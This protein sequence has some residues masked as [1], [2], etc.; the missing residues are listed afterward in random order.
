M[1]LACGKKGPGNE[2]R[3]WGEASEKRLWCDE[4]LQCRFA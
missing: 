1:R 3:V 2:A 4:C